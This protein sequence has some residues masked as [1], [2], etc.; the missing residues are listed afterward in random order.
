M[1]LIINK[2]NKKYINKPN[3]VAPLIAFL[4]VGKITKGSL[5]RT[6]RSKSST[7]INKA[8]KCTALDEDSPVFMANICKMIE[9]FKIMVKWLS[10][11][12]CRPY[13]WKKWS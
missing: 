3:E 2:N 10:P 5:W 6:Y 13:W 9:N 4:W 7:L 8:F 12:K 11:Y 1:W